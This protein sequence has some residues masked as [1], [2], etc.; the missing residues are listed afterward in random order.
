MP[1]VDSSFGRQL[2]RASKQA[3]SSA[4][5]NLESTS[6]PRETSSPLHRRLGLLLKHANDFSWAILGTRAGAAVVL[7][8][9]CVDLVIA[10]CAAPCLRSC[11]SPADQTALAATKTL[12]YLQS[13]VLYSGQ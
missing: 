2:E 5:G 10:F 3:N 9:T 4:E 12:C 8:D 1:D 7:G 11:W 13:C 6:L